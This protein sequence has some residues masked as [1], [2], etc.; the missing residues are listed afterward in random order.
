MSFFAKLFGSNEQESPVKAAEVVEQHPV[1]S[2]LVP[3]YNSRKTVAATLESLQKSHYHHLDVMVVDDGSVEPV[4][5]IVE[6][7]QDKRFR[8]FFKEN[9]GLGLTRNFG[10]DN[11][12]GKYIFFLDSDD[13]IYPDSFVHLIKYSE[14]NDLDVVSGV[15]VRKQYETGTESEWCRHL[16][17]TKQINTFDKRLNQ[18]DDTLSTNKLYRV[19]ALKEK[20][21]YFEKGLYEDKLFTAKLYSKIDRIGL[22]DNRVYVWLVYG[23]QTSITTS[24]S[25]DNFKGRMDAIKNLWQY[26]PALRKT[27]QLGFYINHDLVVYLREFIFYSDKEKQEVYRIAADFIGNNRNLVYKRLVS[28]SL[29]RA[30]LDALCDENETKFLYTAN[31]LSQTYQDEQRVKQ[32]V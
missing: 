27:Y 5:D 15:T 23:N 12:K 3:C 13:V 25:V 17:K 10:I 32:R 31:I 1:I 29:N 14:E 30:C 18:Y 24:K 28:N 21:I 8:Y 4:Q 9:E 11:S 2:V 19:Q 26:L 7:F 16:Y 22:I 20:N 6:S